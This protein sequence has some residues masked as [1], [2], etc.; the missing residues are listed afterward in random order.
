M[1]GVTITTSC[2][3]VGG[4][5]AGM[6]LGV[7]LAR[8]G[9]ETV[10]LEKH[11]D[12]LRDFRGDT[13]HPS[14][15][16]MLA[17]LGWI[18]DFLRLP[19]QE[20]RNVGVDVCGV[21]VPVA[22]FS[23]LPVRCRFVALMPQWD[24]LDFLAGWGATFPSFQL[25]RRSEATGL[26]I[27]G[28]QVVGVQAQEPGR[29]LTVRSR[30][31]V[32]TDGRHSRMRAAAGLT[33]QD[34]GA[35]IDVLWMRLP[36]LP[37]DP[38]AVLGNVRAGHLL[39]LISRGDYWQCAY[40]IPKDGYGAVRQA[41]LDAFRHAVAETAPMLA[42]RT[43]A[44]KSWDDVKVLTVKVDRLEQW[45][46][47]G[48]LCIGDAV[49]AMS[50]IGGVGINLAIQDAVAAGRILA[51]SLRRGEAPDLATLRRVQRRRGWPTR[52]TQRLQVLAQNRIIGPVLAGS[53]DGALPV[54]LRMLQRFPALRRVPARV[55]GLG[56]RPEHTGPHP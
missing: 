34:L 46:R 14:T 52:A 32:A 36:R 55:L 11:A 9:V 26:I 49:H 37:S 35:P 21:H 38:E 7:L 1:T 51:P 43:D 44:L 29:T 54:P 12:F 20:I 6:M 47:P 30:L 23:H 8:A 40:V 5:P 28:D 15:L 45:C 22:D 33:V 48:L 19:H 25:R 18:E 27:E 4:G 24:F 42:G 17:E 10:V 13:I 41:G 39:V 53:G 16:E 3:V 56:F 2:C 50:P 31:V